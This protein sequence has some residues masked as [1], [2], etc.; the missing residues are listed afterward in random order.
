MAR[1]IIFASKNYKS[2]SNQKGIAL[3]LFVFALILVVLAYSVKALNGNELQARQ[4]EKTLTELSDA[5]SALIAWAVN[6]SNRPGLMPYPD[7]SSSDGNYD[8]NSDCYTT[9]TLD[10][11][12]DKL[13]GK[14][15]WRAADDADCANLVS[16]IGQEFKDSS[17][18]HFWYVVSRNLVY[19]YKN[20]AYPTINPGIIDNQ[21][22]A[23]LEVY[24]KNGQLISNKVA[25]VI[26]APGAPLDD[27]DRSGGIKDADDYLDRFDLQAG[28]GAKSNRTYSV[29]DEDFYMGEDSQGV[30]S[31]NATYQQPYYFNDKLVYITID[32]LMAEIEKRAAGEARLALQNYYT[33]SSATPS[34]RFFPYAAAPGS[35]TNPNQCVQ[36]NLQGLLPIN[37]ASSYA[38]TYSSTSPTNPVNNSATCSFAAVSSISF[39][40]TSGSYGA[41]SGAC[42]RQ[43]SNR[44]CKCTGAGSCNTAGGVVRFKC[45]ACGVCTTVA[46]GTSNLG[47]GGFSFTTTGIFST[48]GN[49]FAPSNNSSGSFSL[50]ACTDGAIP[51]SPASNGLPSWFTINGWQNY[52]Y[53]AVSSNCT[54][55]GTNCTTAFPQL[56]VGSKMGVHSLLISAGKPIIA[57]PFASSKAVAQVARPSCD[58]KDY[59]DSIQNTDISQNR[60]TT[61]SPTN[62]PLVNGDWH[63]KYDATNTARGSSYN[64]QLLTVAP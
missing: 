10:G 47:K 19:D 64:D 12:Y 26:I 8:G 35:T 24:D 63:M 43:N 22:Y 38:C 23:W 49:S 60:S 55:S 7:R 30:R 46:T 40:R 48:G 25:A 62:T 5:K 53:Y 61:Q 1:N 34:A 37:T 58:V 15:P 16:G 4:K 11:N 31:D 52:I 29:A 54:S 42:V 18:E 28:G 21:S 59:L 51:L 36:G 50:N 57:S 33:N 9:T 20:S 14:L 17:G 32:E 44:T 2:I 13:L 27:Q 39:T 41:N 56:T 45:D 6:N 3:L